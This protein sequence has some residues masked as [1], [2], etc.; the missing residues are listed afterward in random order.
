MQKIRVGIFLGIQTKINIPPA[1]VVGAQLSWYYWKYAIK[2]DDTVV[3]IGSGLWGDI[4]GCAGLYYLTLT[5]VNTNKLG[6]LVL[7]IND[8]A[9]YKP[10][11]MYFEVVSKN[12]YDAKYGVEL[13]KVEPEAQEF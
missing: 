4:P 10:V 13:L 12:V 3:N 2:S 7:Y 1:P 6:P 9:L 11:L 8:A 5:A